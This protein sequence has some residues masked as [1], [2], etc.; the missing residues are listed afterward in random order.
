MEEAR[1]KVERLEGEL[2]V[3]S[4]RLAE[5]AGE[6]SKSQEAVRQQADHIETESAITQAYAQRCAL[7]RNE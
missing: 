2:A 7:D 6:F 4:T 5:L 3:S 1:A